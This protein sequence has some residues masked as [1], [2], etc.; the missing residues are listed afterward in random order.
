MAVALCA[1]LS[2]PLAT[3]AALA[4]PGG[5]RETLTVT[6]REHIFGF[7]GDTQ[8]FTF[9]YSGSSR[10][11]ARDELFPATHFRK[12]EDECEGR[13]MSNGAT[14]VIGIRMVSEFGSETLT[15]NLLGLHASAGLI[16]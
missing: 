16:G 13:E 2:L 9:I 3:A 10:G 1:L 14:C 8:R 4:C 5:V 7:N 12:T 11:I 6:P 15:V